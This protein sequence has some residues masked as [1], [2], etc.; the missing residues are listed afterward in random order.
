M[1]KFA[2]TIVLAGA[3]AIL[4]GAPASA[5]ENKLLTGTIKID[6][7][8]TVGPITTA[9]AEEF[10]SEAPE[11]RVDGHRR[12]LRLAGKPERQTGEREFSEN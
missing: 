10:R 8:S 7:S 12:R 2:P 3:V 11:V 1:L 5:Q 6:G 9:V 4:A